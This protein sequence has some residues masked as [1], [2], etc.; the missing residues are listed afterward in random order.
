MT[1][2]F[3]TMKARTMITKTLMVKKNATINGNIQA[4][5]ATITGNLQVDGVIIPNDMAPATTAGARQVL[6]YQKRVQCTLNEYKI[7]LPLHPNNGDETLYSNYI[8]N[9]SKGLPHNSLGEVDPTAYQSLLTAVTTGNASDFDGI[10]MGNTHAKLTNP[11]GGL[12]FDLEGADS[13][14]LYMPP[15]PA[16][17]SAERAA[18]AVEDY[19]AALLRDVNFAD[20]GTGI[21]TDSAGLSTMACMEL[22]RLS[23]YNGPKID[24]VVT[25]ATLFRSNIP[26]S[27]GGPYISQFSYLA[28]PFGATSINQQ[29][30]TIDPVATQIASGLP[31]ADFGTVYSEWLN[32]QNGAAPTHSLVFDSTLR[33]IRNGRDLAQNVHLDVLC[34]A[35][36]QAML[37]LFTFCPYN[38]G[39]PY[40]NSA[41]QTGF[42]LFGQPHISGLLPEGCYRALNKQWYEKW[43][44]HRCLRPEEFGG[45]VHNTLTNAATYPLHPDVLTSMAVQKVFQ[46][47][48]TY[49]L[50][51]AYPEYCPYHP[52]YGSGHATVSGFAVTILKAFF[53]GNTVIPNPMEPS[54]DGTTL[55]PYSG[56]P[57]TVTGE[58]NKLAYNV[59]CG[60]CHAGIH[61]RSDSDNSLLLGETWA[62]S[63]LRDQHNLY[64]E[65]FAGFTFQKFDGTTITV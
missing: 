40:N 34:Q 23:G 54:A 27:V 11:Q 13:W 53:N 42:G 56:P 49:L 24:G 38:V 59:A 44:V 18:N 63:V 57:L 29:I 60:R 19:W 16:L 48:G 20:Y 22:S 52:S 45:L 58:L 26:G 65:N 36:Y 1:Q 6:A 17:A 50:P 35:F 8:G 61:Y 4:T 21:G 10:I 30:K 3:N 33:Y 25:P 47:T 7:P 28:C 41:N 64:N 2:R 9:Y 32:I 31:T 12:A 14:A 39:N 46:Q 62:I 43:F 55:N 15:P 37:I 51:Q 5:G